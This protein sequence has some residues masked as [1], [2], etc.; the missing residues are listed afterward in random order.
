MRGEERDKERERDIALPY[1]PVNGSRLEL[2]SY[3]VDVRSFLKE[4]AGDRDPVVNGRPVEGSDV[5]FVSLVHISS[6][7]LYQVMTPEQVHKR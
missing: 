4:V 6:F 5:L 3:S 7:V 2:S 1:C